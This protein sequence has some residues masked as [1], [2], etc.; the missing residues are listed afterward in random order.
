MWIIIAIF[1]NKRRRWRPKKRWLD[2]IGED[3]NEYNITEEMVE[4]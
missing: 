1:H 2:N 3:M 4:N